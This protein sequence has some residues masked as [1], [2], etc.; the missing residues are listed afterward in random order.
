MKAQSLKKNQNQNQSENKTGSGV[1][2]E[3]SNTIT[4][5]TKQEIFVGILTISDRAFQGIYSDESGPELIKQ[6]KAM[7]SDPS[8]PL[9]VSI[10]NKTIV[11]DEK[12]YHYYHFIFGIM[13]IFPI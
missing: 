5:H 11:P 9:I 4:N 6:L 7:E 13:L 10:K 2:N 3:T 1:M 8:W 12:G